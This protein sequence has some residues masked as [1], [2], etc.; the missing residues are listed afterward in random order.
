MFS[1]YWRSA[2][3]ETCP[4]YTDCL[5][6]FYLR[7]CL[8]LALRI[9]VFFFCAF[10]LTFFG[11]WEKGIKSRSWTKP[12]INHAVSNILCSHLVFE[13]WCLDTGTILCCFRHWVLQ[14][15]CRVAWALYP[16]LMWIFRKNMFHTNAQQESC[17]AIVHGY[18]VSKALTFCCK[19]IL[20]VVYLKNFKEVITNC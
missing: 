4:C 11:Y 10:L 17:L 14:V 5:T 16:I 19:N 6:F 2:K 20:V 9:K 3:P 8:L 15:Q 13:L 18:Q 7:F 12:S 1:T